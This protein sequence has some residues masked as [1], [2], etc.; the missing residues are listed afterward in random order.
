MNSVLRWMFLAMYGVFWIFNITYAEA[1]KVQFLG[2]GDLAGYVHNSRWCDGCKRQTAVLKAGDN[3][4]IVSRDLSRDGC[5]KVVDEF[6]GKVSYGIARGENVN[7]EQLNTNDYQHKF[8]AVSSGSGN[9]YR[10]FEFII[11][12]KDNGYEVVYDRHTDPLRAKFNAGYEIPKLRYV[13]GNIVLRNLGSKDG[14]K[15]FD[16][17]KEIRLVWDFEQSKFVSEMGRFTTKYMTPEELYGLKEFEIR[18]LI[19]TKA[20][21]QSNQEPIIFNPHEKIKVKAYILKEETGWY[22]YVEDLYTGSIESLK[23]GSENATDKV[24]LFIHRINTSLENVILWSLDNTRAEF[25][26]GPKPNGYGII[27]LPKPNHKLYGKKKLCEISKGI[28]TFIDLD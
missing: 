23:L 28:Y 14:L 15:M 7:I 1:A 17:D 26:I 19:L 24:H 2:E 16:L 10:S 4:I 5:L 3:R 22:F 13:D 21:L 20:S 18:G 11:G 9:I 12:Y 8:W 6:T 25:I 27:Y